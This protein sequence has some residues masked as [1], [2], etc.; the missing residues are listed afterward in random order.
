MDEQFTDWKPTGWAGVGKKEGK[1]DRSVSVI[2]V[3]LGHGYFPIDGSSAHREGGRGNQPQD[4][5][6]N[7]GGRLP[8]GRAGSPGLGGWTKRWHVGSTCSRP[9]SEG[10]DRSSREASTVIDKGVATLGCNDQKGVET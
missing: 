1:V 6:G 4:S 2:F 9:P 5:P 3:E 8:G 7:L 10:N